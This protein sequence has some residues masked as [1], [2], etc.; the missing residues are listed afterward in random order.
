[1]AGGVGSRFW[2]ASRD[3]KPKQF[4]DVLGTGRNLL[5]MT[6]DRLRHVFPADR[7]YIVTNRIYSAQV[8]EYLPQVPAENIL[9]EPSRNNTAPAIAYAAW[10]IGQKDPSAVLYVSAADHLITKE[11]EFTEVLRKGLAFCSRNN[12][13]L[14]L[15]IRPTRPDTGYGY[16]EL[17]EAA[18]GE[19]FKVRSFREKP[20]AERAEEYLRLGNYAWNSGNFFFSCDTISKEFEQYSSQI[21]SIMEKG[22]AFWNTERES[23]FLTENYPSAESV[24]IDYAILE[25]SEKVF[26]MPVDIGW[27][28]VGT[29][30]SLFEIQSVDGAN[31]VNDSKKINLEDSSGC[32]V[33]TDDASTIMGLGLKDMIIVKDG[34]VLMILPMDRE[35]EVKRIRENYLKKEKLVSGL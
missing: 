20:D 4:L 18:G 27:S 10:K 28:D 9:G 13:I 33:F 32:L 19:V 21:F 3:E 24:S 1:M 31:V 5:Q 8:A 16:I 2:P 23:S 14:T 12:A 30:K 15:G 25:K 17:G 26:T 6:F 34:D 7:I 11:I 29:W 22:R 35:Q